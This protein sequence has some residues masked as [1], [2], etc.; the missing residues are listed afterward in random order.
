M[1]G[2]AAVVVA[3]GGKWRVAASG[4]GDR[5]DPMVGNIFGLGR[6]NWPE[7]GGWRRRPRRKVVA[8]DGDLA[9]K[10]FR[11]PEEM[12]KMEGERDDV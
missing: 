6:K 3:G 11:W 8:G 1:S 5:V 10:L 12:E 9:G 4:G 2:A 7:S